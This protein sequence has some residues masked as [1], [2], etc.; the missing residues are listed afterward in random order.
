MYKSAVDVAQNKLTFHTL[1]VIK[2]INTLMIIIMRRKFL[3]LK[4][5]M[6]IFRPMQLKN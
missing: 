3:C 4:F 6:K 2:F 1:V 5:A